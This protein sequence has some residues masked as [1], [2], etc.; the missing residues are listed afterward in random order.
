MAVERVSRSTHT[1]QM[2][3]RTG[4]IR[5]GLVV[6]ST[7]LTSEGDINR[8]LPLDG[9]A[10]HVTRVAY[11]NPTTPENLRKMAPRLTEAVD[12]LAPGEGLR[13]ICFSC[14][15]ASVSI[16]EA[17]VA[18]AVGKARPNVPLV[19]PTIAARLA[20]SALGARRIAVLTPYLEETTEP[21]IDH[22]TGHGFTVTQTH[23]LGFE[24]DRDMARISI[25]SIV[26]A[27]LAVDTQDAE[28]LFISCT[29]LRA[30]DAIALIEEKT[31]KPV[32]TSNQACAWAMARLGGLHDLHPAGSGRLFKHPLTDFSNGEAA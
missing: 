13:A 25:P 16:G 28:A 27:A 18:A 21:M 2:V 9:V 10:I 8:L 23:C 29:A 1:A 15:A 31:G 17:E 6:L 12:L 11:E 4:E 3:D 32:V 20:L 7:D 14:T 26:E 24:D 22:F 19:T 30:V 5:F